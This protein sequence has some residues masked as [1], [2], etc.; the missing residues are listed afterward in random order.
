MRAPVDDLAI[1]RAAE[2]LRRGG[3]VAFPTETVYG[4]GAR[5]DRDDAVT[6]I[7]E[8][9]GRP[10]ENPTIVH[11]AS[12]DAAFELAHHASDEAR[13]L[14]KSF[15]PGPLT[16]VVRARPGAVSAIATAGGDTVALRVPTHPVARALLERA[17]LPI[18]APSANRSTAIS[19]T[20]AEH[21]EKSLGSDVFVLDAGPTGFGIES[22]IVDV[23]SSPPVVL[24]KGS[25]TLA[26]L[27]SVVPSIEDR[28]ARAAL[29]GVRMQAPGMMA[30]HYAP[31][32]PL[33]LETSSHIADAIGSRTGFLLFE[34]TVAPADA[35]HV[36]RLPVEPK[37]YASGLYACL[38]RLEDADVDAIIVERPPS[39]PAWAAVLDRLGR[40]SSR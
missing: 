24:R 10:A 35:A 1:D 5:A 6:K 30:K 21:V 14:A 38:H 7:Y 11:V 12:S 29:E 18:A 39:E 37:G 26:E 25:I 4:L 40:A 9:K 17:N 19:P 31:K 2:I 13:A 8:A 33:S 27:R 36:E 32:V 20:T 34:G 15:W 28:S 23:S 16:L 3:L 22:T